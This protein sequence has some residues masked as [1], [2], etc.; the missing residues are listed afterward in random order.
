MREPEVDED[1]GE[2]EGGP[3]ETVFSGGVTLRPAGGG[4][5]E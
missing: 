3:A 5:G 2:P 4:S 1:S